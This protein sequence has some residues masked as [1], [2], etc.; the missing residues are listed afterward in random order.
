MIEGILGIKR[1]MSQVFDENGRRTPVTVIEAGPCRVTQIKTKD[2]E[3]YESVQLGFGEKKH[4]RVNKPLRGHAQ[5][6]G[7]NVPQ[8]VREF[9]LVGDEIPQLGQQID[10]SLFQAGDMVDISGVTKGRG[11]QGTVKRHG[12]SRGPETHGSRSQREPG[13]I[14]CVR[15]GRVI[16]GRPLPGHM[17]VKRHTV[18]RLKVVSV[19][20][21]KN[22]LVVKGAVPGMRNG[23]LE[24]RKTKKP[25]KK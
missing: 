8:L 19:D 5:K 23:Y 25:R 24:I 1:G 22:M 18:Q 9:G 7:L 21:E 14:G 15:P 10:V 4:S 20:P 17:G 11:F 16:K 2:K 13:S 6:P 12:F 3:G